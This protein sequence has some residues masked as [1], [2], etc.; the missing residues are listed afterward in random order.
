[1]LLFIILLA[2]TILWTQAA[3]MFVPGPLECN[4]IKY[5]GKVLDLSKALDR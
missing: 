1:M 5:G 3:Q 4:K 2:N